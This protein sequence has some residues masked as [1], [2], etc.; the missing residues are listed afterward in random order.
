MLYGLREALRMLEEEGLA[1][2]F[3]RHDRLAEATRRAVRAW[4]LEI[5]ARNPA[6]YSSSVTAVNLFSPGF[7]GGC[8]AN[9]ELFD[10][11]GTLGY[12][13]IYTG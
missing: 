11:G 3:R 7:T 2:V 9:R 8:P 13:R 12:I 4:G 10:N 5:F 6:E 1:S